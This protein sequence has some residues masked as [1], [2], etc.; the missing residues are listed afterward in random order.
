MKTVNKKAL[1]NYHILESLEAG[2]KLLGP[3]VKSIRA[4]RVEMGQSFAK[5]I[6]GEVYL[7][8][9]NIPA[10][11][12]APLKNYD[13]ARTRKLLLHKDQIQSLIGKLSSSK[14]TLVP[15][16]IYEKNN[17]FK[18]QLGLAKSKKEF[19]KRRVL[20]EKDHLRRIEQEIRGK[21]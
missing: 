17:M 1:H 20:K 18:V 7:V 9:V 14:T 6:N 15:V 13:P 2:I 11:Q 4:G 8:N 10:Y 16:S 19:D 5:I 12:N 3:E 21:G